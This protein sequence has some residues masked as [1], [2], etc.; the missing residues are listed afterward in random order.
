MSE[1]AP[2]NSETLRL[3]V[4]EAR[5]DDVGR[6]IV[7]IDPETLRGIG[8]S[9][10]DVLEIEGRAKTVAKA[11]P[12]YKEQRG[13][14]VVQLDGVGRTNAGVALGQK[15]AIKKVAHAVARRVV[16]APLSAGALQEDEIEHMARRL[17]G[18]AV[19]TGD[20]VRIALFGGSHRDFQVIRTEPDGPVMIHPDTLLAVE[21]ARGGAP[22]QGAREAEDIVT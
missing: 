18:L 16:A 4:V 2:E 21:S 17:D 10:G 1:E 5:R 7:R 6:G 9:P 19:K 14:E 3:T 11:M 22:S 13:Q 20:R 8:A 12:T 15:A